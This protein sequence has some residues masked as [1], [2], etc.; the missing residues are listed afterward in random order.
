MQ[1]VA[2]RKP[3]C[4]LLWINIVRKENVKFVKMNHLWRNHLHNCGKFLFAFILLF[5][6]VWASVSSREWPEGVGSG[7]TPSPA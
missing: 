3:Y 5:T 7:D 6:S 4:F 1:Q 2:N